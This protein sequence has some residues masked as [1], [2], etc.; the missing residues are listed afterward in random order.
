M[1]QPTVEQ[2]VAAGAAA[3]RAGE[4]ERARQLLGDAVR[5]DPRSAQAWLFLAGAVSDDGQRR[6]CLER[7]LALSP[8]HP[9]ALKGLAS[10]T[11]TSATPPAPSAGGPAPAVGGPLLGRLAPTA[12][13]RT[14]SVAPDPDAPSLPVG[15]SA[16]DTTPLLTLPVEPLAA[17]QATDHSLW[18][19][20]FALA[21][22]AL[23]M[24]LA[25]LVVALR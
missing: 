3:L 16:G 13:T 12:V 7:V 9:A 24:G 25:L 19:A 8:G 14:T 5:A 1:S 11:R 20:V 10:L 4:R 22:L 6:Q 15:P 17:P 18:L 2:L 23:L 21:I